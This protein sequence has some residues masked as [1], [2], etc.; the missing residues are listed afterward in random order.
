MS[1]IGVAASFL[2]ATEDS[3]RA[4]ELNRRIDFENFFPDQPD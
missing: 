2:P 3:A 1:C 4:R